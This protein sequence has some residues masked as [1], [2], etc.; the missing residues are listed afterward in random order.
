MPRSR[1]YKPHLHGPRIAQAAGLGIALSVFLTLT[2]P[3]TMYWF[4]TAYFLLPLPWWPVI[5]LI[6]PL[7]L[8]GVLQREC[9]HLRWCFATGGV[10]QGCYGAAQGLFHL[11][12]LSSLGITLA[13]AALGAAGSLALGGLVGGLL[14]V[15]LAKIKQLLWGESIIQDGTLCPQCAYIVSHLPEP[16]CPEC[17]FRFS[18]ADLDP[19]L[20]CT[21]RAWRRFSLRAGL[22][23]AAVAAIYL[24]YPHVLIRGGGRWAPFGVSAQYLALRPYYSR[25]LLLEYLGEGDDVQRVYSASALFFV[26]SPAYGGLARDEEALDALT[27]AATSDLDT[28]VRHAA[29]YS[30]GCL[31]RARLIE[32]LPMILRDDDADVRWK[33]LSLAAGSGMRPYPEGTPWL[34]RAL[35]DPGLSV[36]TKA[37]Q[38]LKANTGQ[39]FPFDPA[40]SET[41]RAI[42]QAVWRAWW[43]ESVAGNKP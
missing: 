40:G 28:A 4:G 15:G 19:G 18:S 2:Q 29:V 24:T 13:E 26:L 37:H 21:R 5:S 1:V 16:R 43:E 11:Q 9:G 41:D 30:I 14:N 32:L 39:S 3:L 22:C 23:L 7:L 6:G 38:R 34:I 35:D 31:D 25:S 12:P 8:L 17:A 10:L 33:G 27:K 36:R 20:P 42:Q